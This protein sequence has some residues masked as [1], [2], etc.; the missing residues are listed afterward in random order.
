DHVDRADWFELITPFR[1]G[2]PIFDPVMILTMTLVMIVVMIESTGMFLALG[3]ICGRTIERPSLSAGL[4]TDGLGTLIGGLFNTFPYTSFSQNVGLVGV[5]GIRSRYVC[6]MG[7]AIMIVLGLV[8]KMGALVESLPVAVLGGAGLV[9]FGMVAA[10]GIRILGGVDFKANR[11]N[12]LIVAISLGM[13][14]IPLI[15]P[16]FSMWLPHAIEPLI[17]SGI[18]LASIT[19]VALNV[20]FN[21]ARE[22]SEDDLRHAALQAEGGH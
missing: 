9:M 20:V 6:V 4:R 14:M 13:G 12:G 2:L 11:F 17:D 5:T 18:L 10:T 3:D 16:Q 1:F 15:A 19:A 7:G 21:G 8:P 22:V